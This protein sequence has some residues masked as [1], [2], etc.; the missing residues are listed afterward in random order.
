MR[1]PSRERVSLVHETVFTTSRKLQPVFPPPRQSARNYVSLVAPLAR[2]RFPHPHPSPS[3][4]PSRVFSRFL[5]C[6]LRVDPV[7]KRYRLKIHRER[8]AF[9]D[10]GHEI[11]VFFIL[12]ETSRAFLLPNIRKAGI[13]DKAISGIWTRTNAICQRS[14]ELAESRCCTS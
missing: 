8:S 3:P 7:A 6:Y 14:R 12:C 1:G 5:R 4:S 11:R 9:P 13:S 10:R 2:S